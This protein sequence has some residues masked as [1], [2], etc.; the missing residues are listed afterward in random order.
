MLIGWFLFISVD[1]SNPIEYL[2]SLFSAPLFTGVSVYEAV[3]LAGLFVI[4]CVAATP[5]PNKIYQKIKNLSIV[6]IAWCLILPTILL[7]CTAYLV[8]S[9]Y[10]PFLYFRF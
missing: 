7:I 9:S 8:D 1:L 10:N 2:S 4:L 3:S 5:L 6:R